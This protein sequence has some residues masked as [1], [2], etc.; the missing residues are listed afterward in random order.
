MRILFQTVMRGDSQI[1]PLSKEVRN[2]LWLG[3][4]VPH[5]SWQKSIAARH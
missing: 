4:Q 1:I 5:K 3:F 2:L